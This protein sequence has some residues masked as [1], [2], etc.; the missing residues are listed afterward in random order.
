MNQQT[1]Y[2]QTP[3]NGEDLPSVEA[4]VII[5]TSGGNLE[6]G[7]CYKNPVEWYLDTNAADFRE[8]PTHWLKP[9]T[10]YFFTPDEFREVA[11]K[12]YESGGYHSFDDFYNQLTESK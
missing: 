3:A 4:T 6:K 8:T 5:K 7:Y 9:T 2:L 12:I 1:V 10:G 11:K